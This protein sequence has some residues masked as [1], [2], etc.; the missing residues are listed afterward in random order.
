MIELYHG[1]AEDIMP[2]LPQGCAD[3][4]IAD[5]PY[6]TTACPW[7]TVIPFD[8]MW[9]CIRH[10]IKPKGAV[11]LFGSQPFTSALVMS[12]PAWFGCEW[13]WSKSNGGGFLN[14]N[15]Y[16]LKRHENIVVFSDGLPTYNAQMRRGKPYRCRSTAAGL[17]TQDQS[18]A[19]WWTVNDGDRYPLS[20][21]EYPNDTGLHPTQKP[22]ALMEYLVKT[23]TNEGETVLDFTA[24]SGTTAVAAYK[25]GRNC[26]AIESDAGYFAIMQRRVRDAEMQP[27]LELSA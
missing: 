4:V 27:M 25:T 16:P 17:T 2:T 13:I 14:A 11:V 6:G 26:I 18:V 5:I 21:V 15:R 23:Y 24:G 8:V 10:V 3:A 1:K 12:N 22:V 20:I 9:Q 7:D 19:G